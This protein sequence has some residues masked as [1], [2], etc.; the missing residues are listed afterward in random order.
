[1]KELKV[2][3]ELELIDVDGKK[4]LFR[5]LSVNRVTYTIVHQWH[6]EKWGFQSVPRSLRKDTWKVTK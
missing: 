5:V 6:S 1:M 2:N 3:D 4:K